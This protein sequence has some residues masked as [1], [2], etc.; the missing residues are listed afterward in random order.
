MTNTRITDPEI[1]ERRYPVVVRAFAIREGSGGAGKHR[2][3]DGVRREIEFLKPITVSVLTERRVFA[4]RGVAGGKDGKTGENALLVLEKGAAD[5]DDDDD[6]ERTKRRVVNLGGKNSV[7]VAAGDILRI[8]SPG[9]G[10]YGEPS[11]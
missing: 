5:D 10:G 6:G 2:G 3:G 11:D 1:L 9:G 4:P 7:S 8:L